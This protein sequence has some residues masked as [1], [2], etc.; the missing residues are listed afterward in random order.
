[1]QTNTAG[2]NP[3]GR[4]ILV[5]PIELEQ[6]AKDSLIV[7]P[8]SVSDRTRLAED[9]AVVIAV[10]PDAWQG[11]SIRAQPGDT[12]IMVKFCGYILKGDDGEFYRFINERD[13]FAVKIEEQQND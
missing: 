10:G 6:R 1:M 4:A 9:R 8:D 13:I 2:W 12:V 3:V 7:L 11:Q 5:K